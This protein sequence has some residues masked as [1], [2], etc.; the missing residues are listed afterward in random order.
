MV[1]HFAIARFTLKKSKPHIPKTK[2]SLLQYSLHG[3]ASSLTESDHHGS[4]VTQQGIMFFRNLGKHYCAQTKCLEW[5]HCK[6]ITTKHATNW[7][8]QIISNYPIKRFVPKR[9]GYLPTTPVSCCWRCCGTSR[10]AVTSTRR[11][12]STTLQTQSSSVV[13]TEAAIASLRVTVLVL[14]RRS[15]QEGLKKQAHSPKCWSRLIS[16]GTIFKTSEKLLLPRLEPLDILNTLLTCA[17]LQARS[18]RQYYSTNS[19]VTKT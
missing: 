6:S 2:T 14:L 4:H 10:A 17:C 3:Y 5:T 11:E 13:R 1:T 16:R 7:S 18:P 8:D 19:P 9:V 15:M 12:S